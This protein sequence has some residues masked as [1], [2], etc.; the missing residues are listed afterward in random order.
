MIT[1][2]P[3]IRRTG[4][5]IAASTQERLRKYHGCKSQSAVYLYYN[6]YVVTNHRFK[7]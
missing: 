3:M 5:L 1:V 2:L 4:T 7:H 6:Y